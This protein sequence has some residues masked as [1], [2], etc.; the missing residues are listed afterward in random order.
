LSFAA[1]FLKTVCNWLSSIGKEYRVIHAGIGAFTDIE[2]LAGGHTLLHI[3][4]IDLE[5]WRRLTPDE[6]ELWMLSIRKNRDIGAQ[7]TEIILWEDLWIS[8]PGIVQSR[9]KALLGQSQRIPARVT[10]VRR[11]DKQAAAEFLESNHLQ[12]MV[13]SRIRYGLFLP[14][15]YYRLLRTDFLATLPPKEMLVAVIT[16]SHPRTFLVNGNPH[17][18]F[19]MIRFSNLT[20]STVVGGLAKLLKAFV[21]D[22]HPDDIMTYA[23][24]EWSR[25]ASYEKLGFEAKSDTPPIRFWLDQHTMRRYSE[26][27]VASLDLADCIPVYNLGSRKFVKVPV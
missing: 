11:I 6:Q 17:K 18:S 15:R 5:N 2:V 13:S 27:Q 14:E 22:F 23:D 12:G 26:K 3:K 4:L 25:G 7:V 10:N 21:A 16:F 1:D 24:L 8:R 9:I 19:E 20:G